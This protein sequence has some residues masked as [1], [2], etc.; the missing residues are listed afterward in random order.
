MAFHPA[1]A[2]DQRGAARQPPPSARA[3]EVLRHCSPLRFTFCEETSAPGPAPARRKPAVRRRDA[4]PTWRCSSRPTATTA[5]V[6]VL[7]GACRPSTAASARG[8][9]GLEVPRS[10]LVTGVVRRSSPRPPTS[11]TRGRGH[12]PHVQA[13]QA[14]GIPA[15]P[16]ASPG[17]V[18][19]GG[20]LERAHRFGHDRPRR[21]SSAGR[22]LIRS[23][24]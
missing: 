12:R 24:S 4:T 6:A 11:P 5:S 16:A 21:W 20:E 22:C 3:L 10:G 18:P 15:D 1:A 7:M 17:G 23:P 9:S 13:P 19:V 2:Q 14:R 8:N